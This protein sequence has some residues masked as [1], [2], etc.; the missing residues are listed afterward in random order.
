MRKV[1]RPDAPSR[2]GAPSEPENG[3]VTRYA[4]F[5]WLAK[6]AREAA[7]VSQ[8]E[9]DAMAGFQDGY[10]GKLEQPD[11]QY[12][13]SAVMPTFDAWLS[14][15]AELGLRLTV[16][17]D[18]KATRRLKLEDHRVNHMRSAQP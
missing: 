13:R 14:A 11:A 12:G 2:I 6:R 5:V 8:L 16:T 3:I 1:H 10:T 17:I 4:Q 7:G 18:A 15:L 9:L